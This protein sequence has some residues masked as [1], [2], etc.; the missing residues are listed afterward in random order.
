MRRTFSSSFWLVAGGALLGCSLTMLSLAGGPVFFR[1]ASAATMQSLVPELGP[2]RLIEGRLAQTGYAPFP[3]PLLPQDHLLIAKTVRRS[4]LQP[5][6]L[7]LYYLAAKNLSLAITSLEEALQKAPGDALLLSDLSSFY[8]ERAR[9][10]G[11]PDDYVASLE[12]ADRAVSAASDSMEATFNRALAL[13]H[14]FLHE[15]AS[16]AWIRYLQIDDSSPWAEEARMRLKKLFA[17]ANRPPAPNR[18]VSLIQSIDAGN[19]DAVARLTAGGPQEARETFEYSILEEWAESVAR[20]HQEQATRQLA[21]ARVIAETLAQYGGDR[22]FQKVVGEMESL[23]GKPPSRQ[24]TATL[25]NS[26]C[27]LSRGLKAQTEGHISTAMREFTAAEAGLRSI[28]SVLEVR[29]LYLLGRCRALSNDYRGAYTSLTRLGQDPLLADYPSLEAQRQERL[30]FIALQNG[31]PMAAIAAHQRALS[32]FNS[33]GE[34]QYTLLAQLSIAD[35]LDSLGQSV[36]AWKYRYRN[37]K[38]VMGVPTKPPNYY[39]SF[40]LNSAFRG[41][42]AQRRLEAALDFMTSMIAIAKTCPEPKI[43]AWALVRRARI[44]AALGRREKARMDFARIVP[45]LKGLSPQEQKMF[46]VGIDTLRNEISE[47]EDRTASSLLHDPILPILPGLSSARIDFDIQQGDT[48]AA[49]S[50]LDKVLVEFEHRRERIAPSGFRVSFLDGA[51]P[52]FERTAA[53]QLH[54]GRPE[55]SLEVLERFR[56]RV[57]LDQIREIS[58]SDTATY[59]SGTSTAPLGWR[60][61]CRRVPAHTLIVVYAVIDGR[62]VT[63]FVTSSGVETLSRQ[64]AWA[65]VSALVERLRGFKAQ[66]QE[67]IRETLE[68]LDRELVSP[69]K[70]ALRAGDRII[71]VPT[72]SLYSVPFAA[73]IDPSSGRFLIQDHAVGIASSASQFIAALERDRSLSTK[74]LASVL[75]VGSPSGNGL[76]VNQLPSLPGSAQEINLL[77]DV[78]YG[79]DTRVL[80][81]SEATPA[82]VLSSLG[83][84][85]IVHLSAHSLANNEDPGRSHLVLS[86]TSGDLSARDI[87]RLRLP[88]TRLV[89]MAACDTQAG[90]VSPS[91]GSLSLSSSFLAAGV[92]AVVGSLWLV[93]DASTARLSVRLHQELRRGADAMTAL[94]TAQLAE[95]ATVSGRADWTWASFQLFGGVAAREPG[96]R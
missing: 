71:F 47:A 54:L 94:R 93:N 96:T 27:R 2:F 30:G 17:V 42:L 92:P 20:G 4:G 15:E 10:E 81:R 53:L 59:A 73:L 55:K 85:D 24:K 80:L 41:A 12:M 1:K 51:Q 79:L 39:W 26:L 50:D 70:S 16:R 76:S 9:V 28:R 56:A 25:I 31:S 32:L 19:L 48:L 82:L 60:E 43:V 67:T 66:S 5:R 57:L 87:L 46:A 89:I 23:A 38:E 88:R 58:A 35:D 83:Q 91:E 63:W 44:E 69:W 8:G 64:A 74:P 68:E 33:L 61:L 78:Y 3:T 52:I 14:L 49:E 45:D 6:E 65:T 7:A 77:R 86:G 34:T 95:L 72:R 36:E 37:L 62:L 84:S 22:I 75:L 29:A 21:G 90:P 11:R 40:T 18:N 13:E